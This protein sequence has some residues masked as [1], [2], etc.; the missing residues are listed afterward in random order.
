MVSNFEKESDALDF[1]IV[2]E[3][4]IKMGWKKGDYLYGGDLALR[5][6]LLKFASILTNHP[7]QMTIAHQTSSDIA[8]LLQMR[9]QP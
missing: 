2:D 8:L 1:H 6:Y 9:I 7:E 4:E 3:K 5:I